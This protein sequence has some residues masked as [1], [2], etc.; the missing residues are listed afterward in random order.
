MR[1]IPRLVSWR[2]RGSLSLGEE[3]QA[4][5]VQSNT[6]LQLVDLLRV[7]IA[8]MCGT[9]HAQSRI[10]AQRLQFRL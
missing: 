3:Y 5:T 9:S 2:D 10:V 6:I 7:S 1:A 8:K 4:E